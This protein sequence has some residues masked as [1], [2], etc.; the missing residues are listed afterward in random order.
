MNETDPTAARFRHRTAEVDAVQWT[1]SNADQLIAFAP[2][3]FATAAPED[4]IDPEDDALVLIEESHWV[5][6]RPGCWV[7]KY[8]DHFAVESDADFREWYEP[9]PVVAPPT[10]RAGWAAAADHLIALRDSLITDPEATGK[11]LAGLERG[12]RELRRLAVEAH[13]T[14]TQQQVQPARGDQFEA[15]LKTQRDAAT[16]YTDAWNA[17]DDALDRYRLHADTGTPLGEHVCEGK[18]V[19]DCEC[20]ESAPVAQQPAE[21]A[22]EETSR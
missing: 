20:L 19:G 1:G 22:D 18:V 13:D 12:A 3:R 2:D 11:Y 21:V 8:P 7:L 9:A 6:I 15:W 5:A 14:G 10:D 16:G 4:R 17:L